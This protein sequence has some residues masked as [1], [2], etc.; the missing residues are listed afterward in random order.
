MFPMHLLAKG[1]LTGMAVQEGSQAEQQSRAAKAMDQHAK[2]SFQ[3]A[4]DDLRDVAQA[5]IWELEGLGSLRLDIMERRL[6]HI[7]EV[8]RRI[9]CIADSPHTQLL[10]RLTRMR[11][12]CAKASAIVHDSHAERVHSALIGVG[13]FG[14]HGACEE[15]S[16]SCCIMHLVKRIK[17]NTAIRW[18]VHGV[19]E[20]SEQKHGRWMPFGRRRRLEKALI[21]TFLDRS[22]Q[23][24][25]AMEAAKT[26]LSRSDAAIMD[27]RD[28]VHA[29][30]RVGHG[31][32]EM[33]D[34]IRQL[35]VRL[36]AAIF[37][38]EE[39]A[40][41]GVQSHAGLDSTMAA[42]DVSA[43]MLHLVESPLLNPQW[44]ISDHFLTTMEEGEQMLSRLGSPMS[45]RGK[46]EEKVPVREEIEKD[47]TWN[48]QSCQLFLP[49]YEPS[50]K[51]GD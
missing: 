46:K 1:I 28:T 41:H 20:V 10:D 8:C 49:I 30:T 32:S 29:L 6:G 22:E 36:D 44:H 37:D 43:T 12:L 15:D 35:D 2:E 38:L 50:S 4:R 42:L 39:A 19:T 51:E 13:A 47:E 48:T 40:K 21:R 3:E 17:A 7:E 16:S 11:L 24:Q 26:N 18:L 9:P 23:A 45:K 25:E 31:A 5:V 27:M 14:A 34:T 33:R